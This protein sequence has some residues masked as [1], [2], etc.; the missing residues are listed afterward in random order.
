MGTVFWGSLC[1]G[2]LIRGMGV[3]IEYGRKGGGGLLGRVCMVEEW[4]IKGAGE[5]GGWR[6]RWLERKERGKKRGIAFDTSIACP[7]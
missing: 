1:Y 7:M 2:F 3:G 5:E 6:G 4:L